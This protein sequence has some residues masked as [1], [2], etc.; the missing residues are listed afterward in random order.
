MAKRIYFKIEKITTND[1][2][3]YFKVFRANSRLEKFLGLYDEY[4]SKK[5]TL[6]EAIEQ[7]ELIISKEPKKVKVVFTQT[8]K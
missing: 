4:K 6:Q 3:E 2:I 7:I 5:D 8:Y 1:E